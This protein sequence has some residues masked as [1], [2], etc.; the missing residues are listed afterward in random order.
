MNGGRIGDRQN[1]PGS[2]E[3]DL[4]KSVRLTGRCQN[5]KEQQGDPCCSFHLTFRPHPRQDLKAHSCS[6]SVRET[7]ERKEFAE[8]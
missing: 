7:F 8:Y 2:G 1:A 4:Q 3:A 6:L 5:D